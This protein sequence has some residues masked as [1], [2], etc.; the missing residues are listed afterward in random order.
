MEEIDSVFAGRR[1]PTRVRPSNPRPANA[2]V[3][4]TLRIIRQY[5]EEDYA[6]DL[7]LNTS[8]LRS[9]QVERLQQKLESLGFTVTL[10]RHVL[11][12][13]PVSE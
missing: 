6:D 3:R 7:V 5:F 10:N 12:A 8:G 2:A 9:R 1:R 13:S 11:T 4:H